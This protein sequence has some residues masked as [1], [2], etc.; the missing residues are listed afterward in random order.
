M[1]KT[2]SYYIFSLLKHNDCVIIT[3]FGG[4]I[5]NEKSAFYNE[6][7]KTAH[8]PSKVISF[9]QRLTQNDGLLA[10]YIAKCENISYNEA[11]VEILKYSR[12]LKLELSRNKSISLPNIGDFY[13]NEFEKIEFKANNEFNFNKDSFGLRTFQINKIKRKSN[14]KLN[15]YA[16]AA[17]IL[18]CIGLS[19][20]SV[21]NNINDE[22][23]LFNLNPVNKNFYQPRYE[24][25]LEELGKETP[26][27]YNVQVSQV[28][29]DLY[30]IN[31]TNYHLS[32]KKCFKLGFG[33]DVQIKIWLDE[34]DKVQ[35]QLCF[36]N[37]SETEYD[38]CYKV[39]KVYN[40]I[41][42]KSDK[43]VV[44]T[45]RGKMR[46]VNLVL[47]ESFIDPYVIANSSQ[48]IEE[49][50]EIINFNDNI[51]KRFVDAIQSVS[52]PNKVKINEP[53]TLITKNNRNIFII[54][55]SFSEINNAHALTKQ[56]KNRGFSN[57][58][59]IEKNQNGLYRVS[60]NDFYTEDEAEM[61]IEQIKEQIS[62][63]WILNEN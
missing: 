20:F 25:N 40:Q 42:S 63:A 36:L 21:N 46:E 24:N 38:D 52:S 54:V 55:G 29:F 56:L 31:G 17:V 9:N 61:A 13:L 45:K 8:P 26:G 51:G 4:F 35:R 18:V 43:I 57:T 14:K 33:R 27:I 50:E 6:L 22:I 49:Q 7:T 3:G 1:K 23:H 5:L 60:V 15:K 58:K 47:E 39:L 2:F 10:N 48:D 53:E 30:K 28:D 16:A 44:L 19:F 59:V 12:K 11:C 41:V 32:T 34:K 62:S 37:V